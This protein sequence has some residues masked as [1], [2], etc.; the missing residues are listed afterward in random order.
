MKIGISHRRNKQDSRGDT[1]VEVL[2]SV[3][4]IS[5]VLG[6]AYLLTSRSLQAGLAAREHTEALN[7]IQGQI[8]RLKSAKES[9]SKSDFDT[10]YRV[11]TPYCL[12]IDANNVVSKKLPTDTVTKPCE[13]DSDH[14]NG[15]GRYHLTITYKSTGTNA[16]TFKFSATWER[17]SNG[18]PESAD[19][20]YRAAK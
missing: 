16:D 17:V 13:V 10:N 2:I 18:S 14:L 4:I 11:A 12:G 6:A 15:G 19:I 9:T 1:I 5:F 3:T 7:F 8:E 20:Y